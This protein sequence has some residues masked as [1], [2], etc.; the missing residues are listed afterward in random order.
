MKDVFKI[1]LHGD[2]SGDVG[3][4]TDTQIEELVEYILSL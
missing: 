3:A 2:V 4:L 1:G